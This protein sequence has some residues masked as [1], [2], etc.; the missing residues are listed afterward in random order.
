ML[1]GVVE[2][3]QILDQETELIGEDVL[4]LPRCSNLMD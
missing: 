3:I 4:P 2:Q 1:E